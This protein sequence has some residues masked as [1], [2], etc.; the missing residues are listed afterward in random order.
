MFD[1]PDEDDEEEALEEA[2]ELPDE[3][4]SVA[5]AVE[6]EPEPELEEP[7]EPLLPEAEAEAVAAEPEAMPADEPVVTLALS[8]P[9]TTVVELPTLMTKE[10]ALP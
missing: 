8:P 1:A 7:D 10:E 3:P 5:D 2:V 6:S 4:L 9:I